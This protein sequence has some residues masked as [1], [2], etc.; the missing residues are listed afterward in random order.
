ME[1]KIYNIKI[2][3]DGDY[4]YLDVESQN[5]RMQNDFNVGGVAS[6][7]LRFKSH[8]ESNLILLSHLETY[9]DKLI[10]IDEPDSNL[11][12]RSCYNLVKTFNKMIKKGCQF[13]CTVHNPILIQAYDEVLN[14]ET[15]KWDT[16]DNFLQSQKKRGKKVKN[17][18]DDIGY[19]KP[20]KTTKGRRK[21]KR[22]L[23][24]LNY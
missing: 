5:P 9:R 13:I 10:L 20:R 1:H 3:G 17:Y 18:D 12:P 15:Q 23:V 24:D 6:V 8:G 4:T 22:K 21:R 19:K 11:S 16:P 14:M 7:M 2:E